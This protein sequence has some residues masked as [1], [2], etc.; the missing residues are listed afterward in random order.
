MLK[1][2]DRKTDRFFAFYARVRLQ[3]VSNGDLKKTGD[4]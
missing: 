4:N 1:T 2:D 3:L